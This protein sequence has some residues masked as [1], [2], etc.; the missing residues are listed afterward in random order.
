[1]DVNEAFEQARKAHQGG[2]LPRAE[3]LYRRVLQDD[4]AHAA[5][6][7]LLGVAWH[8]LGKMQESE[9]ALRE[10]LRLR[11]THVEACNH[12]G[13]VCV[14]VGKPEEAVARFQQALQQRPDFAD[15]R[16]N[17]A[18]TRGSP[19][20]AEHAAAALNVRE[21]GEHRSCQGRLDQAARCYQRAGTRSSPRPPST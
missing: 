4:P 10:A 12:L 17:L 6:W 15:A 9:R 8:G 1:M 5:A 18:I 13:I 16:K 2:D 21:R 14:L 20:G 7:Y 19:A 3:S 11:P